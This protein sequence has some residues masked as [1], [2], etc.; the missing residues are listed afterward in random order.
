[1]KLSIST[2]FLAAYAGCAQFR[3]KFR[4]VFQPK[5]TGIFLTTH[6][7]LLL[8]GLR[9]YIAAG[10]DVEVDFRG[11]ELE[12][13]KNGCTSDKKWVTKCRGGQNRS[14]ET[15]RP[16]DALGAAAVFGLKAFVSEK[17]QKVDVLCRGLFGLCC[18]VGMGFR[19]IR[20]SH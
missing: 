10:G 15:G 1:M 9:H 7:L 6:S 8:S 2:D 13:D 17:V 18:S 12:L 20:S 19:A 11:L 14:L 4:L 3:P 5:S 16:A